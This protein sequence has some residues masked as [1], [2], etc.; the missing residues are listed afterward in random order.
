MSSPAFAVAT[1]KVPQ[2]DGSVLLKPGK[3]VLADEEIGTAEAARFLCLSQRTVELQ[4]D[5]GM[6]KTAWKPGAKPSSRWRIS[7]SEVWARRPSVV[8]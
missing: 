5:Q 1:V 4:C 8:N 6:F 2:P 7:R 3:P